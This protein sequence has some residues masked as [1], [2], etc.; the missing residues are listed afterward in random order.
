MQLWTSTILFNQNYCPTFQSKPAN[1]FYQAWLSLF[2][3]FPAYGWIPTHI[4]NHHKFV[5]KEGDASITGVILRS[6]TGRMP[7]RTSSSPAI[8]K[9]SSWTSTVKASLHWSRLWK[10]HDELAPHIHPELK[11]QSIVSFCFTTY[12]LGMFSDRFRTHR[13]GR[14]ARDTTKPAEKEASSLSLSSNQQQLL[15][16]ALNDCN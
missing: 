3:G 4:H 8:S 10:L 11:Q 13:I 12:V 5:N 7:G 14:V 15:D 2:Y 9:V 6:T 16:D 1:V